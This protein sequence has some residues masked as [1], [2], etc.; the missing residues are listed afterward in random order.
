MIYFDSSRTAVTLPYLCLYSWL[1][2]AMHAR[3]MI[4]QID[5]QL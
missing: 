5:L 1:A 3:V 2:N 4:Y